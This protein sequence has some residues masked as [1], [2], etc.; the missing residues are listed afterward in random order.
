METC[1]G[2]FC[3]FA[4]SNTFAPHLHTSLFIAFS[5]NAEFEILNNLDST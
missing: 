3:G 4:K 5:V 2:G 1:V